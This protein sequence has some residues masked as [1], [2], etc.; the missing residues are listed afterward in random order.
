[1]RIVSLLPS[2]TEIVFD[3]GLSDQLFGVTFECNFPSDASN[4]REIVVGGMDTKHLTPF[5]MV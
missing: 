3:L 2:T 5:E 1:M 4:G